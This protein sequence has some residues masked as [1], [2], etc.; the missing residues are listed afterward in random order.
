MCTLLRMADEHTLGPPRVHVSARLVLV[1]TGCHA[2]AGTG[3]LPR[4]RA[5]Y[6]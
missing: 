3:A 5:Q 6:R 2:S 4:L 1:R